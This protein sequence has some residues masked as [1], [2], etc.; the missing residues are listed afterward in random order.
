MAPALPVIGTQSVNELTLLTVTN[1][2]TE[3]NIHATLGYRLLSP[4]AGMLI[5]SRGIITWTPQQSQSPSTN[6]ITTV[7]TNNDPYDLINPHLSATNTFT[8]VVLEVN[9]A[10]VLRTIA[11]QNAKELIDIKGVSD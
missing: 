4:P 9:V 11:T 7:V 3:S 6:L 5:D 8:V 1:A 2:A 10:P